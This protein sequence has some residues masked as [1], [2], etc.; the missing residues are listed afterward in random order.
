MIVARTM[1]M[2]DDVINNYVIS[3]SRAYRPPK[4]G[5]GM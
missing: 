1:S 2:H 4:A 3:I 5:E